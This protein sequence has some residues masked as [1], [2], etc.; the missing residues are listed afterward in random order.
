MKACARTSKGA[1]A[2]AAERPTSRHH[3]QVVDV[4]ADVGD[5]VGAR[6]SAARISRKRG[7]LVRHALAHDRRCRARARAAPR[8]SE[9]PAGE[10]ARRAGP[11][12]WA[13][14]M[15][16][17]SR[18][19]KALASP[20]SGRSSTVPSV[21]TPSTSVSTSRSSAAAGGQRLV[22]Q[23]ISVF[24]RSCRCSTPST[25]PASSTTGSEVILRSSIRARAAVASSRRPMTTGSRVMHSPAVRSSSV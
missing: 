1:S 19:W 3:G 16:R 20:P 10:D 12:R 23:I 8:A 25:R 11:A 5:L 7:G 6:P 24:H 15:P 17:P 21:R 22:L 9:R 4:V 18:T 14:T 2:G 13:R